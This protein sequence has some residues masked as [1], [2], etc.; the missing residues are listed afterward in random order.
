VLLGTKLHDVEA[1]AAATAPM[2]G[3]ATA[4]V[5]LRNGIDAGEIVA[6]RPGPHHVIGH[7][8]VTSGREPRCASSRSGT[9]R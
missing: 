6:R 1:A 8:R 9:S 4:V 2:V 3:S 5:C 7:G